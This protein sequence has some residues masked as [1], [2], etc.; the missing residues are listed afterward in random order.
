MRPSDS[1]SNADHALSCCTSFGRRVHSCYNCYVSTVKTMT[2]HQ[3]SRSTCVPSTR[4]PSGLVTSFARPHPGLS[5]TLSRGTCGT[6]CTSVVNI[7]IQ[8][9]R[10]S[11]LQALSHLGQAEGSILLD[12]WSLTYCASSLVQGVKHHR[13]HVQ[14]PV[15]EPLLLSLLVFYSYIVIRAGWLI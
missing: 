12:S 13:P 15:A 8:L 9:R 7:C 2:A 1:L 14:S 10:S 5:V 6:A 3:T 11:S 4:V